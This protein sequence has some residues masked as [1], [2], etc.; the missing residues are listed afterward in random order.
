[1]PKKP[2]SLAKMS[3]RKSVLTVRSKNGQ[4][5]IIERNRSKYRKIQKM[6]KNVMETSSEI[7]IS[8]SS[9]LKQFTN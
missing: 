6:P 1:M 2:Y 8:L 9:K 7:V 5:L 3:S 4:I